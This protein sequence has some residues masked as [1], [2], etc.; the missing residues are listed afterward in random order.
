MEGSGRRME[1]QGWWM[2]VRETDSTI[3][4]LQDD[5]TS[6]FRQRSR[7]GARRYGNEDDATNK[8]RHG[9]MTVTSFVTRRRG[10]DAPDERGRVTM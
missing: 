7:A 10:Q 9:G 4:I 3:E 6:R 2:H 8:E 5:A 1:T